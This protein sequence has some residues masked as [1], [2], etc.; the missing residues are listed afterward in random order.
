MPLS[1]LDTVPAWTSWGQVLGMGSVGAAAV[2]VALAGATAGFTIWQ[3]LTGE[4]DVVNAEGTLFVTVTRLWP[5]EAAIGLT[6]AIAAAATTRL[7]IAAVGVQRRAKGR[8][9]APRVL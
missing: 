9:V 6:M 1:R 4:A 3:A 7:V 8:S 2:T 5:A